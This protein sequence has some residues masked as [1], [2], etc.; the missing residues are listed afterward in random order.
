MRS[1]L[2]CLLEAKPEAEISRAER[3]KSIAYENDDVNLCAGSS[4]KPDDVVELLPFP[5]HEQTAL[6][7]LITRQLQLWI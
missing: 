6:D 3:S 4:S 1:Y 2:K 7:R 5:K